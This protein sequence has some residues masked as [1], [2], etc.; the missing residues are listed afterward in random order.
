MFVSTC[1]SVFDVCAIS[2]F[3][4]RLAPANYLSRLLPAED[5]FHCRF[6]TSSTHSGTLYFKPHYSVSVNRK[7]IQFALVIQDT[8]KNWRAKNSIHQITC[9]IS[10]IPKLANGKRI[11]E[12][13]I[14]MPHTRKIVLRFFLLGV[15]LGEPLVNWNNELYARIPKNSKADII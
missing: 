12:A 5:G 9:G 14:P 3:F 6:L 4:G 11:N 15:G 13:I 10:K 2:C 8:P 7:G 1:G